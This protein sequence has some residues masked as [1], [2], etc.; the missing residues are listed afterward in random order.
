MVTT[1]DPF[2][3]EDNPKQVFLDALTYLKQLDIGDVGN[4][5]VEF[6]DASDEDEHNPLAIV[7]CKLHLTDAILYWPIK[8]TILLTIANVAWMHWQLL[9]KLA[10]KL[11]SS[12][13][14]HLSVKGV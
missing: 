9:C 1:P 3:S 5:Q 6:D 8:I 11:S 12:L 7:E 10:T 14:M 2:T 13:V 4:L